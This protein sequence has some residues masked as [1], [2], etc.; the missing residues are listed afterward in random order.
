[1]VLTAKQSSSNI[2]SL[3]CSYDTMTSKLVQEADFPAIFLSGYPVSASLG[4]PDAGYIAFP[5]MAQRVQEVYRQVD[6]PIIVDADG[7]YGSPMNV[8]RAIQG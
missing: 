7:G 8:K 6:V 5:E 2:L 3:P 4:L 1:M